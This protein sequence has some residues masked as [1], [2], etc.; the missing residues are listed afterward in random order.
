MMGTILGGLYFE[1]FDGMKG[2][3]A[4]MFIFSIL[5]TIVGVFI[6]AFNSGNVAEKTTA[7]INHTIT[8]SLDANI[9]TLPGLPPVPSIIQTSP[10]LPITRSVNDEVPDL[11]PPGFVY[12]DSIVF[13]CFYP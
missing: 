6:L 5:M 1:E 10:S 3:D 8:L 4:G 11:P 9:T 7:K 12:F 13:H 2:V